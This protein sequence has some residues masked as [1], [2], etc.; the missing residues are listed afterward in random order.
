MKK[1]KIPKEVKE[2]E[3]SIKRYY[4]K[5]YSQN[6]IKKENINYETFDIRFQNTYFEEL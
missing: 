1:M 4:D 5:K 3:S 6:E 2:K